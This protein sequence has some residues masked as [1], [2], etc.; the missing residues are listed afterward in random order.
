MSS[1]GTSASG[2]TIQVAPVDWSAP[3]DPSVTV[4]YQW[5]RCD[6]TGANCNPIAG[7]TA[8]SYTLTGADLGFT[9]HA[10]V[11]GTNAWGTTSLV[12]T[13]VTPPIGAPVN[14][15]APRISGDSSG[16]GHTL[17]V[18]DG[19]WLNSPTSFQ[20]QWYSC[21]ANGLNCSAIGDA[22]TAT[23]QTTGGDVVGTSLI[24]EVDATNGRG[25]P[26][27]FSSPAAIGAPYATVAPLL[28]STDTFTPIAE[29]GD[30]L[31]VRQGT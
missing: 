29:P 9:L 2:P 17:T 10:S 7:A 6:A 3:Q 30:T 5:V 13:T 19:T 14:T 28:S 20:Y 31:S 1:S 23:Y 25:T 18:S 4:T 8:S 26:T 11:D 24:A 15:D 22:T 27:A 16:P 21:D 12:S